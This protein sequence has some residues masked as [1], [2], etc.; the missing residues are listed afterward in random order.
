M[1]LTEDDIELCITDEEE[2]IERSVLIH[3]ENEEKA[4]QLKQQI[5]DDN[6]LRELIEKDIQ[7]CKTDLKCPKNDD[8]IDYL[9]KLLEESKK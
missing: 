8:L 5:L 9:Q 4:K 6:K 1:K 7:R 3:T 2:L